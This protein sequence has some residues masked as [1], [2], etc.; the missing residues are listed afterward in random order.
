[1]TDESKDKAGTRKE[2]L[3]EAADKEEGDR[4]TK[5]KLKKKKKDKKKK[6]KKKKKEKTSKSSGEKTVPTREEQP[7]EDDERSRK[8]K[9]KRKESSTTTTT[10]TASPSGS[11]KRARS[12]SNLSQ[13]SHN[14]SINDPVKEDSSKL[15]K[16]A[17]PIV[18]SSAIF[19]SV[20]AETVPE[21]TMHDVD[22]DKDSAA[23]NNRNPHNDS[24][25]TL[26]L[27]Y[28][29]V[30]PPWSDAEYKK[31]L[32]KVERLAQQAQVTGRARVAKEGLNCT[33]TGTR[34]GILQFCR[35]LRRWQ[36]VFLGTEF[37]LTHDLPV[38]TSRFHQLKIIPVQELVHYGLEGRKAPPIALYHGQHLEPADYHQKLAQK[39]SVVIDV[40]NHYEAAIGR[41]DPPNSTWLD[42]KMRKSTEFPAWL[43]SDQTKEQLRGKQVLMY[44]TGGIRCE[45]A[46]ALLKYKMEHDPTVKDLGIQGV[47]QLQGGIDKYFKQFP[48]G[49]YWKG[50]NYVF[51]R[52]TA[53]AP[54]ALEQELYQG[55]KK[56]ATD[57]SSNSAA[58]PENEATAQD[59]QTEQAVHAKYLNGQAKGAESGASNGA[60]EEKPH[61]PMGKCEACGKPWDKYAGKRRC[62]TCGVPSLTCRDCYQADVEGRKKLDRNVRCDLCVDQNIRSKKELRAREERELKAYE[63]RMEQIGLLHPPPLEDGNQVEEHR[64]D[65]ANREIDNSSD[66]DVTPAPNPNQVT[67][68]F[69]KNM[70]RRQMT[71][72]ILMQHLP[73]ISHIVWRLNGKSRQFFGQGWVEMRTPED[74]AKAV[75]QSGS[76]VICGRPLY[77][78]YQP[79]DGKDLWPPP[80]SKVA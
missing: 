38:H 14:H 6:D 45:R 76:L 42:P 51:D 7:I 78:E 16:Q 37:K 34:D 22:E 9:K 65:A 21:T 1:M 47:Y 56:A 70:C 48:E 80:K 23:V 24:T 32:S 26:L 3:T 52:R 10:T 69:L 72:E 49:G 79:P 13:A 27:F 29:Y 53:H 59:D 62:P 63:A 54:A 35:S 71:E 39:D 2:E 33:L 58:D 46:S 12:E 50:K 67:R 66:F 75:A 8:K 43:D 11:R 68:L 41:F 18:E 64:R 31:S 17:R 55:K 44:C 5:K 15:Q 61:L 4:L 30:E 57:K 74:A 20:E 19:N 77:A 25:C 60:S 28:Q 40:R 36:S 73:G